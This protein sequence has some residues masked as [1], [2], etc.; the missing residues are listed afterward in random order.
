MNLLSLQRV[1]LNSSDTAQIETKNKIIEI[2]ANLFTSLPLNFENIV[3]T[4]SL[5]RYLEDILSENLM[6]SVLN[7]RNNES[8]NVM[9]VI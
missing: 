5:I 2:L 1:Y 3:R 8:F 7:S 9:E 4:F 6:N